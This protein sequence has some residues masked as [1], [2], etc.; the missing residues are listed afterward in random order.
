LQQYDWPGNIRELQ[1]VI[2]RAVILSRDARLRLDLAFPENPQ[3]TT[4]QSPASHY[5]RP[6]VTF[7][8]EAKRKQGERDNLIAALTQARGKVYGRGGAAE[9]LGVK[10]TTLA[11]RLKALGIKRPADVSPAM[12]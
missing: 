6:T 7:V 3:R 5:V 12:R 4:R 10:P 11:S 9:L 8:P 2:E 1:H